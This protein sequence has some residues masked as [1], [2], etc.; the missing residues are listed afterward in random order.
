MI[1]PMMPK[2]KLLIESFYHLFKSFFKQNVQTLI[3]YSNYLGVIIL[4]YLQSHVKKSSDLL[5]HINVHVHINVHRSITH[6]SPTLVVEEL[7]WVYTV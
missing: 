3:I 6:C 5:K 2:V 1:Y 4:T 7:I